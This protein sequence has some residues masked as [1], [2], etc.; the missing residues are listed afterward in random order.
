MADLD[1][2]EKRQSAS[3]IAGPPFIAGV[4]P[5]AS[6]DAEWRQQAGWSYS[7]IAAADV[8]YRD[9]DIYLYS[10]YIAQSA[11][12]TMY[13]TQQNVTAAH[14]VAQQQDYADYL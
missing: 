12:D 9:A 8:T 5:N 4:T 7:G 1:N 6:A 2:R 10:H 11:L 14:Y 3:G 13:I